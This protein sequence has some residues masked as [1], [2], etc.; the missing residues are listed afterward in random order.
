MGTAKRGDSISLDRANVSSVSVP[1]GAYVWTAIGPIPAASLVPSAEVAIIDQNG[2]VTTTAIET[3]KRLDPRPV[4]HFLT[5][6]G[7]VVLDNRSVVTTRD[8][9]EFVGNLAG[10]VTRDAKL[11]LEL[12]RASDLPSGKESGTPRDIHRSSL[13]LLDLPVGPRA[14]FPWNGAR[15]RPPS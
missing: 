6:A 12:A 8:G 4:T 5:T 2:R 13:S 3:V 9:K 14:T 15:Y 1:V 10:R 7:E 11:R